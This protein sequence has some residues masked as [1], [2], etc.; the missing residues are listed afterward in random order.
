MNPTLYEAVASKG[1]LFA[2]AKRDLVMVHVKEQN[3]AKKK[4][5][6]V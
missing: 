6:E 4:Q 2:I 1:K 5:I 3:E